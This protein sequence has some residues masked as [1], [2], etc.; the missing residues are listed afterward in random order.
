MI[1][2]EIFYGVKCDRC[3]K[4]HNDGDHEFWND[5]HSPVEYA[6]DSDWIEKENKH[7]C[8]DCYELSDEAGEILVYEEWPKELKTL[9]TFVDKIIKGWSR[10]VFEY[11]DRF[12]V[13]CNLRNGL[14]MHDRNYISSLLSDKLIKIDVS[15]EWPNL[16]VLIKK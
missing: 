4:I 9:V 13:K 3:G 14:N 10:N 15:S 11:N 7:Y 5:E 2:K 6:M 16:S 12:E 1:I 8:D